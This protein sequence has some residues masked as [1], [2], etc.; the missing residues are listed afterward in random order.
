MR[1]RAAHVIDAA[2]ARAIEARIAKLEAQC[3][4]EVVCAIH[5]RADAYREA[6]WLAFA[7]G[8]VLAALLAV[9]AGMVDPA[10]PGATSLI[11][12]IVLVL[13][14]GAAFAMLAMAWPRGALLLVDRARQAHEARRRAKELFFER[15]L[16]RTSRHHT[17]LVFATL[18]ERKVEI[19]ADTGFDGRVPPQ[20]WNGIVSAMIPRLRAGD[21]AGAFMAALDAIEKLIAHHGFTAPDDAADEIPN[22]L[23]QARGA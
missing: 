13:A 9:G 4:V 18:L 7:L 8:T 10:W 15:A 6:P 11:A 14:V 20:A 23:I 5:R 1:R 16:H 2:A 22:S 17:V 21:C 19:I 12:H 3:G